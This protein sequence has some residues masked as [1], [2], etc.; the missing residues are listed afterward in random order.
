MPDQQRY[1]LDEARKELHRIGCER[2]GHPVQDNRDQY[3]GWITN[4]AYPA[5]APLYSGPI[6]TQRGPLE[7][8]CGRYLWMPR[9]TQ[10]V[11]DG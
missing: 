10:A 3:G 7:C 5:S 2:L 8:K 6:P 9:D 4:M 1:T 11:S